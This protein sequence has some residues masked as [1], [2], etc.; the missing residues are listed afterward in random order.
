MA[1]DPTS[2]FAALVGAPETL[3]DHLDEAALLI[4]A[5]ADPSTDIVRYLAELDDLAAECETPRLADVA[6]H[7]FAVEGFRGNTDDYYDPRNS[8]L[9]DVIDRRLG[10][11]ITLG[12]VLIEVARRRGIRL[13]GVNLPGHFLVRLVDEPTPLLVDP[14]NGGAL[15]G[16]HEARQRFHAVKGD[17]AP[18]DPA[19]LEPVGPLAIVARMLANLRQIHTLRRDGVGL[20]WVLHLR[21]LLP[22]ASLEQRSERAGA[23][24]AL[25]RFGEAAT[26]LE[27][28]AE[29]ATDQRADALFAKAR[30]LRARLN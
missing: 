23:L 19:H 4:A 10:I 2:R 25:A 22:G 28:L 6:H 21:G 20:E 18:F 30:R 15:L 3:A 29:E 17:A 8:Y 11:P 16:P 5:H 24:V 12:V 26:V 9:G 7:L 14:F 27:D 1:V 13:A